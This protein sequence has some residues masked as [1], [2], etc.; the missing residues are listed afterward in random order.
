MELQ[1]SSARIDL[2]DQISGNMV[3]ISFYDFKFVFFDT[4][5]F[6]IIYINS[7]IPFYAALQLHCDHSLSIYFYQWLW[8]MARYRSIRVPFPAA[9]MIALSTF[10]H[11][12]ISPLFFSQSLQSH[13]TLLHICIA[14]ANILQIQTPRFP[15]IFAPVAPQ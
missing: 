5:W 6:G 11:V 1:S 15:L 10:I 2:L 3:R 7:D 12:P 9:I 13:N 14:V 8:C 4:F